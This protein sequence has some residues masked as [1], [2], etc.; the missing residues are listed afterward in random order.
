MDRLKVLLLPWVLIVP[1]MVAGC[2]PTIDSF[3][4]DRYPDDTW[5]GGAVELPIGEGITDTLDV[6][7]GDH[8]DWKKMICDHRGTIDLKVRIY[9]NGHSGHLQILNPKKVVVLSQELVPGQEA[10]VV[11]I[12]VVHPGTWYIGISLRGGRV[13]YDMRADWR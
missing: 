8:T 9:R 7:G 6:P 12:P 2:G 13:R 1:G 4:P 3:P 5:R 10:Y 11:E